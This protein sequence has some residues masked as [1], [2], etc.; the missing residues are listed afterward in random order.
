MRKQLLRSV[1]LVGCGA[2]VVGVLGFFVGVDAAPQGGQPPF[3]NAVEQREEMIQELREIK[4]LLKEQNALLRTMT[5]KG[6]ADA[7]P[8]R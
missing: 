3:R 4:L 8:R 5:A 7:T 2:A 6:H 1:G